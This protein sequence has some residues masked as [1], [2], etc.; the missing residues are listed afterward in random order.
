MFERSHPAVI[1]GRG[2]RVKP[3]ET[4]DARKHIDSADRPALEPELASEL[5]ADPLQMRPDLVLLPLDDD[6]VVF[7][8]K[9]Q[10]LVGL[11]ASAAFVLRML[12]E[13]TS[14][15]EIAEALVSEGITPPEEAARWVTT[16][17]DALG[18]QGLLANR[19][20]PA[21]RR[22]Q[23][24]EDEEY[25]AR[26]ARKMPP[27]APFQP[28]LERRYRLL[29]T[30]GLIRF[31]HVAQVRLVDAVIGHFAID[32]CSVPTTVID[33]QA[34]TLEDGHFRSD[35][36]R[37]GEPAG[38]VMRLSGVGPLA[39][40]ALIQ[41]AVNAHDF[42]FCIH[43][44]VVGTGKSCILLP[45]AA[46]SGKS[47]LTAALI[48]RGFG[49]FS[50]EV[51]LIERTTLLVPPVPIAICVKSTGWDLMARY[52]PEISTLP[53]HR[54]GDGKV[55]RY[56]P[57]PAGAAQQPPA[58]VSHIIFPR[59]DKDAPTELKPIARSEALRRLMGECQALRQR[60]DRE[61]VANLIR[62]IAGIDCYALTFSSLD[63]AAELV[64]ATVN[65]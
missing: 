52:Y 54:R 26:L 55:V 17:L 24:S 43:S 64:A 20:A 60:L 38:F 46:G 1:D 12:Q 41:A 34:V 7:S 47:S 35:A 18:S 32:N 53:I 27:Y 45:A 25:L 13:G 29:E 4:D 14:A 28:A 49:Y 8:E 50:D 39:K 21:G 19:A 44:G 22:G 65:A 61:N 33:I 2:A 51:A 56:I 31:A 30:C 59:Y 16:V 15:S 11:N 42:L 40:G 36:Y 62:W 5:Q 3:V 10:S 37:D 58:P 48:Q 23:A 9:A 63:E 57:P 6:V